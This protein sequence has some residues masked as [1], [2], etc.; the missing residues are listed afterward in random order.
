MADDNSWVWIDCR[1]AREVEE[2]WRLSGK[3][4][5]ALAPSNRLESFTD[6]K[7]SHPARFK[8]V[9]RSTLQKFSDSCRRPLE[10]FYPS[11]NELAR[12]K[13]EQASQLGSSNGR[14]VSS[15]DA[16]MLEQL[17]RQLCGFYELYHYATS[18]RQASKVSVCLLHVSGF[19]ATRSVIRCELHDNTQTRPYFRLVGHITTIAGFLEWS[20]GPD[21]ELVV[22]RGFSYL[23]VGEKYPDF[24]LYGIFLSLSG[25]GKL[26]YP[27][28]ARGALR[29]LG[30]TA[31]EAIRNSIFDLRA[32]EAEP[33]ELLK[34]SVGG[35]LGDSQERKLLRSD[36]LE[37][38]EATILPRINN[39]ISADAAPRALTVPR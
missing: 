34:N 23:P 22:C 27:V 2:E 29:F 33:E 20:L 36:I 15:S 39:V 26:D 7:S 3:P 4:I 37:Q 30:E 32:G 31:N 35:Y 25:D 11:Q 17:Y 1:K 14:S 28:A 19:D 10:Y 6:K 12:W 24:T 9:R 38:I 5:K 13:E 8:R 16:K 21:H 18:T